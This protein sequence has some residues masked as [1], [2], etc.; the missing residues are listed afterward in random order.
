MSRPIAFSKSKKP[1]ATTSR[2][3]RP[4]SHLRA[5]ASPRADNRVEPPQA[6][7]ATLSIFAPLARREPTTMNCRRRPPCHPCASAPPRANNPVEPPQASPATLSVFAPL[8]RREPTTMNCRRRSPSHPC[9]SAPP[10]A[11]NP[12][13]P[14]QASPVSFSAL[15]SKKAQR[16]YK[17]PQANAIGNYMPHKY[18]IPNCILRVRCSTKTALPLMSVTV[19]F[20]KAT[21]LRPCV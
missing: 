10:R 7:P 4:L 20:P 12:V 6:S 17:P 15:A 5:S 3:R 1:S 16:H 18:P 19:T 21:L 8:A 9:A 13:E 14:P 11:N 2:R